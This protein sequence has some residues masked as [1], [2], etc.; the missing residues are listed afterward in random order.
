MS[1][2]PLRA[3]LPPPAHLQLNSSSPAGPNAPL[4]LGSAGRGGV[5]LSGLGQQPLPPPSADGG[6]GGPMGP[7]DTP[8]YSSSL[9]S[10]N[11]KFNTIHGGKRPLPSINHYE[12]AAEARLGSGKDPAYYARRRDNFNQYHLSTL[13]RSSSMRGGKNDPLMLGGP[14]GGGNV[15]GAGDAGRGSNGSSDSSCGGVGVGGGPGGGPG[16]GAQVV[17]SAY[18]TTTRSVKKVYL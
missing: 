13:G 11:N 9:L 16:K 10:S 15:G 17:D 12:S 5:T 7:H 1:A 14:G 3:G 2:N 8:N 4:L 18:G 6:G